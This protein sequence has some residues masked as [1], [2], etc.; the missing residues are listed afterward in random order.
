MTSSTTPAQTPVIEKFAYVPEDYRVAVQIDRLAEFR[1]DFRRAV[2]VARLYR[3][4]FQLYVEAREQRFVNFE[5]FDFRAGSGAFGDFRADFLRQ[6]VAQNIEAQAAPRVVHR[7]RHRSGSFLPASMETNRKTFRAPRKFKKVLPAR[8]KA[9]CFR[10]A[11][12][13]Q[14]KRAFPPGSAPSIAF[15]IVSSLWLR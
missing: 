5:K 15:W 11:Y 3:Q 1:P 12:R 6:R 8:L 4:V 9:F 14:N 10:R 7:R 13:R 2:A